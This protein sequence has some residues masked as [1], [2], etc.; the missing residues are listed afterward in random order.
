MGY[1]MQ[2][3]ESKFR[4]KSENKVKALEAIKA[5]MEPETLKT[6]GNGG[7]WSGGEKTEVWYSWVTTKDVL[8]AKTVEDAI[9]CWGWESET[10]EESGDI[11]DCYFPESKIGQEEIMFRAIAPYVEE[12]SYFHMLGEDGAQWRWYFDGKDVEEQTPA[13]ISWK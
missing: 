4:I 9:Q 7:S 1:N 10:D 12:G 8:E 3:L 2:N 5:L 13:K 11:V 6:N